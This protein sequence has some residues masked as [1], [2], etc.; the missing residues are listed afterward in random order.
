[1]KKVY[2]FLGA[3]LLIA[4]TTTM[5]IAQRPR[6][7]DTTQSAN[8]STVPKPPPAPQ[9][10]TAKYEGGIFGFNKKQ[11]GT[12][13]FDDVNQRLVFRN[14]ENKEVLAIPY[15]SV[16]GAYADTQSH[17]PTGAKVVGSLPLPYGA[18]LPAWFIK[19][20]YR[21]LA[22]Q[23]SDAD[24]KMVGMTSFKL[25]NKELLS[26]VLNTL[27]EKAGLEARGEMFIRRK[28]AKQP[29]M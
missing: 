10:F 1:M 16:T 2:T 28:G 11:V 6:T 12:L 15:S 17:R 23:F 4:L 5:A 27:A 25:E 9:T 13:N 22:L 14:Q 18:N 26:S 20:K 8:T 24:T 19:K 21:Y 3:G 7:T 29:D